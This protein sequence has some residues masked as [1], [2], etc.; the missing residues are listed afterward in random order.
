MTTLIIEQ[1]R[2]WQAAGG[3]QTWCAAWDRAIAVTEPVWTGRDITWDGMQLAEG[4]AALATGIYLVAAQDGLAVGEVT[5]EQI[6][7][8]MAP[9]RPWDIVRMWEQRLQLLGHDLEDPTDPV[10]VCW[11]RLRHDDT[12]PPIVQNWDYGHSEFRWG[13]ALVNSLRALLA[14]R[15]SLAF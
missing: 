2:Q 6:E 5:S 12:P 11:Q 15:W 9:Q 14:P 3:P 7:D 4:T 1:L 10:S 8:L 13:P